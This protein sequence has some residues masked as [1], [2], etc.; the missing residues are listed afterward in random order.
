M[1]SEKKIDSS[2]LGNFLIGGFSKTHRLDHDLLGGGILLY[3]KEDIPSNLL[4]VEIKP[5]EDI[6]I[7]VYFYVIDLH[8]DKWLINCSYNPHK[9]MI[10]DHLH[11]LSEKL[12][13][14]SSSYN[15]FIILDDFNIEM[16]EQQIKAFCDNY[17]FTKSHRAT[18]ML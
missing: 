3:V 6:F 12:D 15:N 4:K 16:Q 8:N 1:I 7:F 5:I 9:N 18:I 14:Y 11:T 10:G 2:P 17:S 13:I